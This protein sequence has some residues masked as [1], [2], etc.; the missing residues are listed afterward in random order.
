MEAS[1]GKLLKFE[2]RT[3]SAVPQEAFSGHAQIIF[4]TGV[5]YERGPAPQPVPRFTPV[6]PKRKRG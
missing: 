2:R 4:F 3:P 1:L 5:R 6:K